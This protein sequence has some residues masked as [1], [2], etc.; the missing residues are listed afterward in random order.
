M[1]D[2]HVMETT[3]PLG[4]LVPSAANV[5]RVNSE[6]GRAGLAASIAAHG[7]IQNLVVRKAGKGKYEVV[8]GGRRLGA[9]RQL[10]KDGGAVRGV[11]VDKDYPV[12][13][14]VQDDAGEE[15]SL[16]ENVQREAMHPVDEVLA[17][18]RLV[19]QGVAVEDIAA[20]FGQSV[21]TVRQR[22][23]L[24]ALSPRVLDEL[25]E[26]GMTLE[27]AKA[28]AISDDHAAQEAAWF[29]RDGWSRNPANLRAAL[30]S[31]HVRATDRLARFVGLE[32]YEQAGGTVLR[33]LF[34]EDGD[35]WLPDRNVLLRLAAARLQAVAEE[36][37]GHG[38]KWVEGSLEGPFANQNGFGRIYPERRELTDEEQAEL[39]RLAEAFDELEAALEGFAEGDPAIAEAEARQEDIQRRVEAIRKGTERYLPEEQALAGCFVVISY[40]GDVQVVAGVV[41]PE[42]R[43]ALTAL[44]AREVAGVAVAAAA[45]EVAAPEGRRMA[46]T[47]VEEL[48]AVRT[49]ALRVELSRNPAV[50]LAALL[51][52]LVMRA[53]YGHKAFR[54]GSAVE[55]SGQLRALAPS[56][57][58]PDACQ[59]LAVWDAVAEAWNGN[60]PAEAGGLWPWLLAQEQAVLLDL[61]AVVA[62]ANLNGVRARQDADPSRLAQ[63]EQVAGALGFDVAAWWTPGEAFLSRLSNAEIVEAMREAGCA[64][65]AVLTVARVSKADAVHLAVKAM[66]GKGWLPEVL[67]PARAAS[68]DAVEAEAA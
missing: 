59:P 63:A 16:A 55:V 24:A 41:K 47:L 35:T 15:T 66:A 30:T 13:V 33:D 43:K 48:T 57:R 4:R 17:Y 36:L 10:A 19:E 12:R 53:F 9:L 61:L 18:G 38:W 42:D 6:S 1:T 26:G 29:G 37:R 68:T 34:A 45:D 32:A 62:A 58:D 51:H 46:E 23:K 5:R 56:V 11:A 21:V 67:R 14:V 65:D 44:R 28:L 49:A 27:Q 8:A 31:E 22:L 25:R 64:E 60:L 3:V 40:E 50:A 52:P 54:H 2:N 7:L 39:S 20:R